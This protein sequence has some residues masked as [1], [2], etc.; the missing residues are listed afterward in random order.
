MKVASNNTFSYRGEVTVSIKNK[1]VTF[2]SFMINQG[3]KHLL[4]TVTRALAGYSIKEFV[5]RYVDIVHGSPKLE[6]SPSC[7]VQPCLLSGVVYG[8]PAEATDSEGVLLLNSIITYEDKRNIATLDN[9]KIVLRDASSNILAY[10]ESAT[11][12]DLW[13]K[14]TDGSEALIEWKMI[15]TNKEKA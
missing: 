6:D 1:G 15:F 8:A 13:E 14:I 7:L 12:N 4:D 5:P 2:P 10:V 3:T 9:P 11:V